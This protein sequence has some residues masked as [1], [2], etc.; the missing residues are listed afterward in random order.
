MK[1]LILRLAL[2]PLS[3]LTQ[4]VLVIRHFLYDKGI[5]RSRKFSD[6]AVIAIGNLSMGGTGKTP[7]TQFLADQ[8][9]KS[10]NVAVLSRGYGRKTKG[11]RWVFE[12]SDYL[13]TGDEPLLLKIKFPELPVAVCEKRV[14]GVERIL[15]EMPDRTLIL[16]DDALQHRPIVPTVSIL[17]TT[18]DLP[19]TDDYLIPAGTL[20]DLRS[21]ARIADAVVVTKTPKEVKTQQKQSLENK[22]KKYSDAP[23]FYAK[24]VN[25]ISHPDFN[26]YTA[27]AIP[28]KGM[29]ITTLANPSYLRKY[30]EHKGIN[31]LQHR[32]F[33]DHQ[34]IPESMWIETL[35]KCIS[36]HMVCYMTEKEWVKV[37]EKIKTMHPDV[38]RIVSVKFEIEN[39][40][41]FMDVL[42]KKIYNEKNY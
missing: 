38:F 42:L 28:K 5:L 9:K 15:C 13:E 18:W 10:F 17:L 7:M 37:P 32:A 21:R 41:L 22:I 3:L 23:V 1:S 16:L 31:L 20:R 6:V 39:K 26:G 30:L 35:H 40:E 36:E 4:L 34:C 19:F 27:E 25:S 8:L 11:F 24:L 14:E 2:F 12:Y 29:L 33:R